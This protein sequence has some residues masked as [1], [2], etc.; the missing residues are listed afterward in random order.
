MYTKVKG[1]DN[2][3]RLISTL[4]IVSLL[5]VPSFA[6]YAE[7]N[8]IP[9]NPIIDANV[10]MAKRIGSALYDAAI[11]KELNSN[12]NTQPNII[13]PILIAVHI[14]AAKLVLKPTAEEVIKKMLNSN[15]KETQEIK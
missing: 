11:E 6:V 5:F 12:L 4:L 13:W 8:T 15:L 10:D 3:K 2:M 7:E 9:I 1:D 14:N